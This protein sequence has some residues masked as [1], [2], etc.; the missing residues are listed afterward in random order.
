MNWSLRI[1]QF[2]RWMS[3]ALAL[4]VVATSVALAQKEPVM[5]MSYVPLAPLALLFLSGAYLFALPH[6]PRRSARHGASPEEP[7]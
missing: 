6:L 4:A 1:R 2:H 3:A 7:A 5:W